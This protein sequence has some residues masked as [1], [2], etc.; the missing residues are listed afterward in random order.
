MY[1]LILLSKSI[2][3]SELSWAHV[4][5]HKIC[6]LLSIKYTEELWTNNGVFQC[7]NLLVEILKVKHILV[8]AFHNF[9][10]V[11]LKLYVLL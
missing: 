11:T 10:F 2:Q 9:R 5:P 6:I 8:C 4:F 3:I 1:L 7:M